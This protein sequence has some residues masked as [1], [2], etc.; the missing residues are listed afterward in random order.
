MRDRYQWGR[1]FSGYTILLTAGSR[2]AQAN[3]TLAAGDVQ[4][5]KDG[6]AFADI[7]GGGTFGDFVAVAPASG[8]QVKVTLSDA[9]CQAKSI[10]IRFKDVAGAEWDEQTLVLSAMDAREG[11]VGLKMPTGFDER[12]GLVSANITRSGYPSMGVLY[13][14]STS[15]LA[16]DFDTRQLLGALI[17]NEDKGTSFIIVGG[18][19][20]DDSDDTTDSVFGVCKDNPYFNC[21][22]GG[23]VEVNDNWTGGASEGTNGSGWTFVVQYTDQTYPVSGE[24]L[25]IYFKPGFIMDATLND[26][27]DLRR[28]HITQTVSN[29]AA[30]SAIGAT[31]NGIGMYAEGDGTGAGFKIVGGGASTGALHVTNNSSNGAAVKFEATGSGPNHHGLWLVG[32]VGGHGL[33]AE[34]GAGYDGINAAGNTTG[35]GIRATG[36]A[37]GAGVMFVGGATSG[38][39]ASFA[40]TNNAPG[41]LSQ[42]EGT[43]NGID[44]IGGETANGLM[45]RGGSTTG[46]GIWAYAQTSGAGMQVVGT[47][48]GSG[49]VAS[50]DGVG[51]G[52]AATGGASGHGLSATGQDGARFTAISGSGILATGSGNTNAGIHAVCDGYGLRAQSTSDSHGIYAQGEGTG[53]AIRVTSDAGNA[54]E[55]NSQGIGLHVASV[56]DDAVHFEASAVGSVGLHAE[57]E[58][59]G[60]QALAVNAT[61]GIGMK[62]DGADGASGKDADAAEWVA[63]GGGDAT[64]AK[65]DQIIADTE[66]LQ[67]QIGTAGAGLTAVPWNAS[68]DAEV[69]SEVTDALTAYPVTANGPTHAEMTAEHGTINTNID[70]N[71]TK[72]DA[73]QTTADAIETDTQD[74]QTQIGTAGAGLTDL[75]GMSTAMKAEV[76]AAAMAATADGMSWEDILAI[77][78][79][80]AQGNFVKA[81]DTITFY[82]QDGI[83]ALWSVDVT[84]TTRTRN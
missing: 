38:A 69:E 72:I 62:A 43:G 32:S 18:Y 76:A 81:G 17:Y 13:T 40:G 77:L 80:M 10:M 2:N 14:D 1:G 35:V 50:G 82:A 9:Q 21:T 64:E 44:T 31:S 19:F 75:G 12:S 15:P 27:L 53:N 5:S 33:R 68:W 66:D 30:F 11:L 84:T 42:G 29:E 6:G 56:N 57:G 47:N 45:C 41:I 61:T 16:T 54:I 36:G 28:M 79:S 83:A 25:F 55:V 67:A 59:I 7:E 20:F 74:L 65:Q 63:G 4:I 60:L 34:S 24:D 48:A 8:V 78:L 70:A 58:A 26:M 3:P 22:E 23:S 73:V 49:L 37:T 39:G 71:E 46:A 52:I 51:S